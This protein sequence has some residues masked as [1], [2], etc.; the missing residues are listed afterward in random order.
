LDARDRFRDMLRLD[1]APT[2]RE[3][4]FTG[5]GLNWRKRNAHG[6]WAIINVQK[7]AWGDGGSVDAYVNLSIVPE[8]VRKFNAWYDARPL[9][10]QPSGASGLWRAR[11][12]PE[13]E[14]RRWG[15]DWSFGDG[16]AAGEYAAALVSQ[17]RSQGVPILDKLLDRTVLLK[18]LRKQDPKVETG[19]LLTWNTTALSALML[20]DDASQDS[21]PALLATLREQAAHEENSARSNQIRAVVTWVES[22]LAGN[23]LQ[24]IA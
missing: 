15:T 6:D 10:K 9:P 8:A 5:S 4:G 23:E 14:D 7:S 20:S 22:R 19:W 2:L 17:L 16:S 13:S 18:Y 12:K 24:F 3:L 11:L 21:L 1:V